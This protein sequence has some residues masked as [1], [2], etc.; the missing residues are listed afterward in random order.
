MLATSPATAHP[1][2]V[3][4]PWRLDP[5]QVLAALESEALPFALVGAWAGG[6]AIVGSEPVRVA[7]GSEDPFALLDELPPLDGR[8]PGRRRGLVRLARVSARGAGRAGAAGREQA[9][10]RC[11]SFTSPTTTMC[12]ART[13]MECGGSRRWSRRSAGMRSIDRAARLWDLL[14]DTGVAEGAGRPRPLRLS[15]AVAEHHLRAVAE[16]R[17]RIAA[18]EIFQANICLRLDGEYRGSRNGAAAVALG[19]GAVPQYA[20]AFDTPDGGIVSLSPELFLRREGRTVRTGPI[21]GT[22]VRSVRPGTGRGGARAPA[23]VGQGR[24]RARDDR[25]PDAQ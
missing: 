9:R 3:R 25:R 24:R 6:G 2:R 11:P 13:A 23:G 14:A 1:Q 15:R 20:A 21:K 22:A 4:L 18:G 8:M 16:C 12:C 5:A 10:W 17:E 19:R 7:D